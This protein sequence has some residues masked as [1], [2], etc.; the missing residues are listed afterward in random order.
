MTFTPDLKISAGNDEALISLIASPAGSFLP[1]GET[2]PITWN[3]GYKLS[4]LKVGKQP[5]NVR[6]SVED[7]D[8]LL[9]V[10]EEYKEVTL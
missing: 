9:K 1:R 5:V 6:L 3:D 8:L 2:R 7:A 10:L 4:I